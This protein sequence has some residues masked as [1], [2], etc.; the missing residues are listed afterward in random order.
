M[1]ENKN[2][3][4]IA[5]DK[6]FVNDSTVLISDI[7]FVT[8][9]KYLL[10]QLKLQD[11]CNFLRCQLHTNQ[12]R[13]V[14]FHVLSPNAGEITQGYGVAIKCGATKADFDRTIGIHPTVSEVLLI[15]SHCKP[16]KFISS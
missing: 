5:N 7:L 8:I 3:I 4:L 16:C 11:C 1:L 6:Q 10:V 12:E 15:T 9:V 2:S 14:G 13:V